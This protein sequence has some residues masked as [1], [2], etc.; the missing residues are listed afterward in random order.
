MNG[1]VIG[2]FIY[3]WAFMIGVIVFGKIFGFMNDTKTTIIVLI[4]A[5]I[6]FVVWMIGRSAA[7]RKREVKAWEAEQARMAAKKGRNKRR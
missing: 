4:A 5:A 3:F 1:G 2:T 6:V 7:A